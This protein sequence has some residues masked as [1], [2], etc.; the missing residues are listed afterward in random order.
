MKMTNLEY[1]HNLVFGNLAIPEEQVVTIPT[2]TTEI[3]WYTQVGIVLRSA[4]DIEKY[5]E[6][7]D[8]KK[9]I[10]SKYTGYAPYDV[11]KH[12]LDYNTGKLI[13]CED[14]DMMLD[15]HN[16]IHFGKLDPVF[17]P[18]YKKS[19]YSSNK[20]TTVYTSFTAA[21]ALCTK[22]MLNNIIAGGRF[23][24]DTG[25][26]CP[27]K[28]DEYGARLNR[29]RA[30]F[31]DLHNTL[32][33]V[34]FVSI[35]TNLLSKLLAGTS[36]GYEIETCSSSVY[37]PEIVEYGL[38][39]LTDGSLSYR[40]K[41]FASL[42]IHN[43]HQLQMVFNGIQVIQKDSKVDSTCSLHVHVGN[44]PKTKEFFVA[45]YML[46]QR[47]QDEILGILPHYLRNPTQIAGKSKNYAAPLPRL[48][49]MTDNLTPLLS[50][51]DNA[52]MQ[53]YNCFIGTETEWKSFEEEKKSP[54]SR[55]WNSASRYVQMNMVNAFLK[56]GGTIE[57][58]AHPP[59]LNVQ[60]VYLW[61]ALIAAIIYY[62]KHNTIKILGSVRNREKII[63]QDV[64]DYFIQSNSSL[65]PLHKVLSDYIAYQTDKRIEEEI[66][67]ITNGNSGGGLGRRYE[68]YRTQFSREVAEDTKLFDIEYEI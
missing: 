53:I 45:L 24:E 18:K 40:G 22:S 30:N 28:L 48:R 31:N 36:I 4:E 23:G 12:V 67:A 25:Y 27:Y 38:I 54:W 26:S 7:P 2:F 60:K 49:L 10:Y 58:R 13:D 9:Y 47:L 68:I 52:F 15:Q 34:N 62:T 14:G 21:K 50:Q 1:Q 51:V 39:P 42:P 65:A 17:N 32:K 66:E 3:G 46:Y 6:I 56:P 16:T 37:P 59:T 19:S 61:T 11:K 63:L 57:F 44:F 5:K 43:K 33:S 35:N 55:S 20:D 8:S 41:E 64:V 29:T